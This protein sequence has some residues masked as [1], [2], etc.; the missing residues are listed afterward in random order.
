M[1]TE[2]VW[3]HP[4]AIAEAHAAYEWYRTHNPE[5]AESFMAELDRGIKMILE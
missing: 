5:I 3:F 2:R 1:G 4:E